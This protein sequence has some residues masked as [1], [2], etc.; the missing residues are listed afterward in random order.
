[1]C[2]LCVT[3][4]GWRDECVDHWSKWLWEEFSVQDP[5]WTVACLWRSALQTRTRA[6]VLH[7]AEVILLL[8]LSLLFFIL[9]RTRANVQDNILNYIDLCR[10]VHS[11]IDFNTF[12]TVWNRDTKILGKLYNSPESPGSYLVNWSAGIY[13][14]AQDGRS[15]IIGD[16]YNCRKLLL[17]KTF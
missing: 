10:Y 15:L 13:G 2:V 9:V 11:E 1:M 6:H 16:S 4:G 12:H 8:L 7:P 14:T 3:S 17:L 5:Q